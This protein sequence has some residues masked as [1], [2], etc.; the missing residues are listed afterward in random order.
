MSTIYYIYYDDDAC[1]QLSV[2]TPLSHIDLLVYFYL[3]V[4]SNPITCVAYC[5]PAE[6]FLEQ[7]T[8]PRVFL[9][10]ES[11]SCL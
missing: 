3:F 11:T 7:I 8:L 9:L 4:C 10:I 5:T 6:G 2:L 1:K